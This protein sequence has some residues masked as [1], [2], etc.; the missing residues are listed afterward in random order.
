MDVKPL[1]PALGAEI[2]GIDLSS[3]VDDASFRAIHDAWLE[4]C[5]LLFRDQRLDEPA[6]VAFSRRFGPLEPPP[7]SER[8]RREEAGSAV[9][10]EVWIISNVVEDGEAIGSL[11]AGEAEWHTDM[12]YIEAPPSASLLHAKQVPP[13][14][15]DTHFANMYKALDDMPAPLR[16]QIAGRQA[17]HDASYTSAGDLRQGAEGVTD[18]SNAPGCQHPIERTHPGSG[19][20]A[21]YLGRR[22]NGYIAGLELAESER[23]LD[24]LWAHCTQDAFVYQHRWRPGDLLVWDNRCTIHRRDAFDSN[25]RR[26]MLRTQVAGER[27]D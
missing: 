25:A 20:T 6:L 19:R 4:H 3:G 14:G 17:K 9:C 21:L 23:V 15:G 22:R 12:S 13:A 18:P 11:G 7:A 10:P 8:R 26:I 5:L 1:G 27:P 16:G 24:R 2:R